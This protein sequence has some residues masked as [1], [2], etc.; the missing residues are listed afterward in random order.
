MV[1]TSQGKEVE[2]IY[3][4]NVTKA[5]KLFDFLLEKGHIKLPAN[6]VILPPNQLKNKKFC[7]YHSTTSHTTNDCRI[8]Q[9]HIQRTIQ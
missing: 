2:E 7:K 5:D 9:Q 8:F 4:F 3:D 1:P 6:N